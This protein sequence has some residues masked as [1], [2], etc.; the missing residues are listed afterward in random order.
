LSGGLIFYPL[1]FTLLSAFAAS[2]AVSP[3]ISVG[4][5]AIVIM[6]KCEHGERI[7][8][9]CLTENC[10]NKEP[11][12]CE[13]CLKKYH[14]HLTHGLQLTEEELCL[15]MKKFA[16]DNAVKP[17]CRILQEAVYSYFNEVK[18]ELLNA[19]EASCKNIIN[20]I[21]YPYLFATN[22]LTTYKRLKNKEYRKINPKEL[23]AFYE[24]A[25]RTT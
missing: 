24:M 18:T 22:A 17:K 20:Q 8:H 9:F 10:Q 13:L 6:N 16:L 23:R 21:G 4:Y 3:L 2:F 11:G 12:A 19:L 7:S 5:I 25:S 14:T 1:T 15:L